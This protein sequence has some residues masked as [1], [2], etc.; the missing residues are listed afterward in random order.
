MIRIVLALAILGFYILLARTCLK[1][2]KL[3]FTLQNIAVFVVSG[4]VVGL[5][6]LLTYGAELSEQQGHLGSEPQLL[7]LFSVPLIAATLAS[8]IAVKIYNWS[9]K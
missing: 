4:A 9:K 2:M 7:S 6:T 8:I 1:L 3:P 5:T